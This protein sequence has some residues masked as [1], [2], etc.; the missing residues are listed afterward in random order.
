MRDLQALRPRLLDA[1][2]EDV[3]PGDVTSRLLVPEGARAQARILAKAP[4]TVAGLPVAA[5]VLRLATAGDLTILHHVA[6]GI[7]VAPGD[8]LLEAVG[9][10]RGL[11][12]GERTALN[13][14]IHL[15]GIATLTRRFVDA[16]AG[17]GARILD[18]RKTTPGLRDLEKYAVRM[19]GGHNHRHALY[20]A[21]LVKEN[22][23]KF[24]PDPRRALAGRPPGMPLIME[25]ENLDEFRMAMETGADV[26][27][28]DECGLEE[29]AE[30]RRIRGSRSR[31]EI[32]VSGGIRLDNVRAWAEAGA[33]RISVG[34][35]THS[36]PALDLSMKLTSA[37]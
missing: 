20:D 5:E 18:T 36:A 30:A 3:G 16:V 21:I 12:A 17:T 31:P 22:H 24:A 23:L 19:G 1:L 4:G 29:V 28:L 7:A 25:A 32:E 27:M 2:C 35:L 34:A 10:A 11:L 13:Y 15:S 37:G 9:S 14:L 26:V 8:L 33:E 6:D